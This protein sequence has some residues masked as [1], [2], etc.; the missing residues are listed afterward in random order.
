M[1]SVDSRAG[2][3]RAGFIRVAVVVALV[4]TGVSVFLITGDP[5]SFASRLVGNVSILT[6]FIFATV[7]CVRAARRPSSARR[8]WVALSIATGLSALSGIFF[9]GSVISGEESPPDPSI[10]IFSVVSY[11]VPLVVAMFCFPRVPQLRISRYRTILDAVVI[12]TAVMVISEATVLHNVYRAADLST[13]S[14]WTSAAFPIADVVICA[15]AIT[16]GMR[17]YA[18]NRLAWLWFGV[19]A[20]TLAIT[21]SIFVVLLA[22]RPVSADQLTGSPLAVGWMVAGALFGLCTL[23]PSRTPSKPPRDLAVFIQLLPYGP[24][25]GAYLILFIK[26]AR[27]DVLLLVG[28]LLLLLLVLARQVI[29]VYENVNLTRHLEET[30]AARTAELAEAAS[31]VN[32]SNDAIVGVSSDN[33]ITAWNPAAERLYGRPAA[34]AM[35]R[36]PTF[37]TDDELA[38]MT[39]L[40]AAAA[41]VNGSPLANLELDWLHPDGATIPLSI[42]IS[43]IL[44]GETVRGVSFFGQDI[45]KRREAEAALELAREEALESSRLKSDF[46]ATMS[47]EIRTPMNGVIGLTSLLLTTELDDQQHQYAE[48]VRTAG[49]ALM[50]LIN[51][52]LDFSK[53]EAGKVVLDPSD[54]DLRDMVEDLGTL[55]APAAFAKRLELI[56]F[57]GP[58]VPQVVHGDAGRIRQ[59]VLNLASNAVK[60]TASGEV[61]VKV[62]T[63]TR[64]GD[65]ARLRFSVSDTGIGI[66]E[67]DQQRVF[68]SFSQADTSTTRRFGG[69]GLGLAISRRLVDAMGGELGLTSEEGQGSIFWFEIDVPVRAAHAG[70]RRRPHPGLLTGRRVLVVDDNATNRTILEAQLSSWQMEPELV[71]DAVGALRQL[72]LRAAEGRPYEVALLDMEMPDVDGLQLARSMRADPEL[73]GVPV[74]ML[75]SSMQPDPVALRSAGIGRWLNK[76]LRSSDLYEALVRLLSPPHSGGAA[77]RGHDRAT[78]A[79][80]TTRQG[81]VLVV[82]DNHLNQLVAEGALARLGYEVHSVANGAEALDAIATMAFSAVLMDCHMPLMDGFDATAEVRR[83][84]SSGPR[85][86]I[87]AM[88]AAASTEDR[89]RCLE[90]GMDDYVSKPIDLMALRALMDRWVHRADATDEPVPSAPLGEERAVDLMVGLPVLNR[91]QLAGLDELRTSEGSS[92]LTSIVHGYVTQSGD[93]LAAMR[94]AAR[95]GDVDALWAAAHELQE[96]SAAVGA[97]RVATLC[98]KLQEAGPQPAAT[99]GDGLLAELEIELTQAAGQLTEWASPESGT[100]PAVI[101]LP[102][103]Q[104][105]VR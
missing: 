37:L 86:P 91:N 92:L 36:P 17:Q 102:P 39:E 85:T 95:M 63:V 68:E 101:G 32:S 76:P 47:H 45:T 56:A 51:D 100:A 26:F 24:V 14:G 44:D 77:S 61:A 62:E 3:S 2:A 30:V 42:T 38:Q 53:L 83:R 103:E 57:C 64:D 79:S 60:F 82:E 90:A 27:E 41:A 59:V 75:T 35:G 8:G 87:I 96:A 74:I 13:V 4:I 31:I 16:L 28:E 93:R 97:G 105:P 5:R 25:L 58:E 52:I 54:F 12:T 11:A 88:T 10:E 33:V 65:Q 43:P 34:A 7:C 66:A 71:K 29:I 40:V 81:R 20:V 9:V 104:V 1:T 98:G 49:E 15:V 84:E 50:T 19:G 48:G 67:G 94:Q 23:V 46:L 70:S 78:P 72:R 99:V 6:A 22:S 55:L 21:H 73:R 18:A 69:T 89:R 80:L